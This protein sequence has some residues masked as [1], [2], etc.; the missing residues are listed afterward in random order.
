MAC[1]R[2]AIRRYSANV[3]AKIG[4]EI[5]VQ[6]KTQSKLFSA[7]SVAKQYSSG[8]N[9]N[10]ALF[11]LGT[12]GTLPTVNK[13]C[14]ELALKTSRLLNATVANECRFDRKHYFYPDMP[15]GYQI[16]QHE[17]PIAKNGYLD[18]YVREADDY[19]RRANIIQVQLEMDSGKLIHDKNQDLVDLNRAGVGL[20]EIVTDPCFNSSK[21]ASTF[22]ENLRWTLMENEISDCLMHLGEL[23]VDANVS[24]SSE[25]AKGNVIE[26][27]NINS[28]NDV[29]IALDYEI[30]RQKNI[31]KKG[32]TVEAETRSV[33][34][35]K[36]VSSREK[37]ESHDYRFLPEPN[38]PRIAIEKEWLYEIDLNL[39]KPLYLHYIN[40]VGLSVAHTFDMLYDKGL[41]DFVDEFLK[42]V[43]VN[44]KVKLLLEEFPV[45]IQ[46]FEG[47][48]PP[49][50]EVIPIYAELTK[51][52]VEDEITRLTFIELVKFYVN[53]QS[54]S[55]KEKIC[56]DDLWR[57]REVDQINKVVDI[58]VNDANR[59]HL[60]KAKA[61][62]P[63]FFNRLRNQIVTVTRKRIKIVDAETALRMRLD[64]IRE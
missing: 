34:D 3:T 24:V 51:Y 41:K 31:L 10:V 6:L 20:V 43:E 28:F 5:H 58:I 32:G 46:Q 63:K 37:G 1:G 19:K 22:V 2:I 53:D 18:Y 59:E 7:A 35:G 57:I 54:I 16:T 14:I 9:Q 23:R 42:F 39:N 38:I 56:Q 48:F 45:I 26:L 64:Q 62:K 55:V 36:T 27:K 21:E 15:T 61:G 29:R 33:V 25:D 17:L 4:L 30:N 52:L 13:K 11:D 44:D 50:K 49:K 8:S 40:N 12:P 47:T 60:I